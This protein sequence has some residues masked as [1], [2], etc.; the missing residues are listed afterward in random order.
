MSCD[1]RVDRLDATTGHATDHAM[2]DVALHDMAGLVLGVTVKP[3]HGIISRPVAARA[4]RTIQL[5]A[6]MRPR[7][8]GE[9]PG[10]GF[11]MQ[12]DD[13][14]PA[15]DSIRVPGTSLTVTSGEPVAVVVHNR[16]TFPFSVHWHGIE[17][18]SY[19]DG[20]AGWSGVA[21]R[22]AP[23]IAPGDSFAAH[24]TPPRGTFIYHTHNEWGAELASGLY[25][26]LIVLEPGARYDP[27]FDRTIVIA[28]GGPGLSP[29]TAINWLTSPDTMRMVAGETYRIRFIDISSNDAHVVALNG[30][31][32]TIAWRSLARDGRPLPLDRQVVQPARFNTAAG[33]TMDFEF[34]PR[35][36][37]AYSLQFTRVVAAKPVS[38]PAAMP[39]QV[40]APE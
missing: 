34:V 16:T 1:Q 2:S 10:Y 26:P 9:Q 21:K 36:A 5:F 32:G 18:E 20:V 29:P 14:V 33:I 4:E 24:F 6:D 23:L 22:V 28:S 30:P 17:L 27:R 25:G 13:R 8:Y 7:V 19:N 39:I 37:G 11:V 3:R 15:R 31:T 38:V 12:A 40:T 35:V